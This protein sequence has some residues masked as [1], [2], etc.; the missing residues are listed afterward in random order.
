[1]DAKVGDITVKTFIDTGWG[2]T[3][4]NESLLEVLGIAPDG[5]QVE[6]GTS[7][8]GQVAKWVDIGHVRMGGLDLDHHR[9][10]FGDD[11]AIHAD[12]KFS[13][14]LH[15]GP[16]FLAGHRLLID[17]KHNQAALVRGAGHVEPTLQGN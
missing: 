17:R 13:P 14:Y 12:K 5:P 4:A 16:M 15:V 7:T 1:V 9:V 2:Y 11:N 10:D 6:I 8:M 3:A